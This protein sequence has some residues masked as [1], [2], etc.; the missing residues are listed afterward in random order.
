MRCTLAATA[1]SFTMLTEKDINSAVTDGES[2]FDA[3]VRSSSRQLHLVSA[4]SLLFFS[5]NSSD[6]LNQMQSTDA[7]CGVALN[8][9]TPIS[10]LIS[11]VFVAVFTLRV[12]KC[13]TMTT[14]SSP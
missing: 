11:A 14:T 2:M 8:I 10:K 4:I 13:S 5:R 3:D 9:R 6:L 12:L 7:A 1:L